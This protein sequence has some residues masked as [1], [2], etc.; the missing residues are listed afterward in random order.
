MPLQRLAGFKDVA[1]LAG[2]VRIFS[3]VLLICRPPLL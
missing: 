3:P 2:A 1:E